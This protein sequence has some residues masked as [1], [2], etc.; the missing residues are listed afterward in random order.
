MKSLILSL[1]SR[2]NGRAFTD[3]ARGPHG[4]PP[5]HP[6]DRV[7][8]MMIRFRDWDREYD[9]QGEDLERVALLLDGHEL[10]DIGLKPSAHPTERRFTIPRLVA[11]RESRVPYRMRAV[12]LAVPA[13][14]AD[15]FQ[16]EIELVKPYLTSGSIIGALVLIATG[17]RDNEHPPMSYVWDPHPISSSADRTD[18]FVFLQVNSDDRPGLR[19]RCS[20]WIRLKQHYIFDGIVREDEPS[21]RA[22]AS[23]ADLWPLFEEISLVPHR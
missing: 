14:S 4:E 10:P 17:R 2:D 6:L 21:D 23:F 15:A 19:D 8:S 13:Q 16:T 3:S 9:G 11:F 5:Y 1:L 22:F 20:C 18:V 7:T 12:C